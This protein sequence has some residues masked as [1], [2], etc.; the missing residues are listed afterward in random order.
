MYLTHDHTLERT[1]NGT[2]VFEEKTAAEIDRLRTKKGNKIMSLEEF[3]KFLDG[4]ENLYVEF[5]MKTAPK[6]LYPRPG[7][8]I[9]WRKSI[10]R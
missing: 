5:E 9:M 3:C 7:W 10:A 2:G 6:E 1:T 4:K 8:R